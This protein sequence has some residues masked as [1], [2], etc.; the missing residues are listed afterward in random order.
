MI[1]KLIA[2]ALRQRFVVIAAAIAT[3]IAGIWAFRTMPVDAYPDLSP[4]KVEIGHRSGPATPPRR[5]SA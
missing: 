4:P 1:H 2:V 5:S 3:L